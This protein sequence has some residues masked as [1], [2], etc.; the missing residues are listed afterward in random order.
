MISADDAYHG[1]YMSFVTTPFG[2][3]IRMKGEDTE[4]RKK[5]Y[6]YLI[7]KGLFSTFVIAHLVIFALYFSVNRVLPVGGA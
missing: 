6:R 2:K 5:E 4:V 1:S 7:I 3:Q